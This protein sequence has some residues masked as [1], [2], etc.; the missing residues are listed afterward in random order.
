MQN[1]GIAWHRNAISPHCMDLRARGPTV[2]TPADGQPRRRGGGQAAVVPVPAR[3][4]NQQRDHAEA[5]GGNWPAE[6]TACFDLVFADAPFPAEGKSNVEGI[7]DPPYY[8][9][10]QFD[11]VLHPPPSLLPPVFPLPDLY[12]EWSVIQI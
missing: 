10:F 3:V 6:V 2:Q 11:K 1:L 9:W 4:P 8:E 12:Y 5:G 7:F